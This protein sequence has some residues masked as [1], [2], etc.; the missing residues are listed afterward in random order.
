MKAKQGLAFSIKTFHDTGLKC[1]AVPLA[2]LENVY[3]DAKL[4]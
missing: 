3:A 2:I 4:I 1:G